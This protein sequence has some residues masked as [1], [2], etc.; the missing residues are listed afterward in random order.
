MLVVQSTTSI[1][2]G[3]MRGQFSYLLLI[4]FVNICTKFLQNNL[5]FFSYSLS[6]RQ[7]EPSRFN[8]FIKCS[9]WYCINVPRTHSIL[10]KYKTNQKI[11]THARST[12][13][14]DEQIHA[15]DSYGTA[16]LHIFLYT[17][18]DSVKLILAKRLTQ[19]QNEHKEV[20]Q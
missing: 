6:L 1:L 3:E 11:S 18:T 10:I 8:T 7:N 4:S 12:L 2:V 15:R 17:N 14:Q 19:Y 16:S 9:T 5:K 20:K 13:I